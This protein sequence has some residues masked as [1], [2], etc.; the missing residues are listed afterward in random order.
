MFH[1]FFSYVIFVHSLRYII[2]FCI[3]L[4]LS[5]L[6]HNWVCNKGR[7]N[8][9]TMIVIKRKIVSYF[10]Q[11]VLIIQCCFCS[12]KQR[13]LLCQYALANRCS[14]VYLCAYCC[15]YLLLNWIRYVLLCCLLSLLSSQLFPSMYIR[16]NYSVSFAFSWF[17]RL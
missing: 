2:L 14:H 5:H 7:K 9:V 6:F 13:T 4:L 12:F 17:C 15:F 10:L 8:T 1:Y 3:R 16:D 11:F